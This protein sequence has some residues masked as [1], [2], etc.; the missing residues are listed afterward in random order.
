MKLSRRKFLTIAG[1][2]LLGIAP[3][4]VLGSNLDS[5]AHYGRALDTL[6]VRAA[7]HDQATIVKRIWADSILRLTGTQ[8]DWFRVA[9]GYVERTEVQ[10]MLPY[11]PQTV[12]TLPQVPFW[13]EVAAPV[14]P[15]HAWCAVAAPL[16]TRVGHGGVLR[17]ID[18]LADG[19]YAVESD[20]SAQLGWTQAVFWQ[21]APE[22]TPDVD[23]VRLEISLS[24]QT[25]HVYN[26]KRRV[27]SAPIATGQALQ[28][29]VYSVQSRQAGGICCETENGVFH[30]VPWHIGFGNYGLVG[31]YWHN[32]FGKPYA[33]RAIQVSPIIARWLYRQMRESSTVVITS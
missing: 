5:P 16:V 7:P 26:G 6:R 11:A 3:E 25:L 27:M 12:F 1:V 4:A 13:A 21:A 14:A 28:T 33:G 2:T 10:A 15:V 23:D 31:A 24:E 18:A 17:V 30:G 8:G 29:G 20:K 32:R 22:D 19:W 9:E